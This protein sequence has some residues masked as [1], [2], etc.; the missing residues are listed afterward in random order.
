M[1]DEV[2]KIQMVQ[3][4][5]QDLEPHIFSE[6]PLEAA[7]AQF[8]FVAQYKTYFVRVL[9]RSLFYRLPE[10]R[11]GMQQQRAT[12]MIES[13]REALPLL[14]DSSERKDYASREEHI[15]WGA[16]Q[17][18]VDEFLEARFGLQATSE[19]TTT[20]SSSRAQTRGQKTRALGTSIVE[21][22]V[23]IGTA[24]GV[25][26]DPLEKLSDRAHVVIGAERNK[27]LCV[28]YEKR[29]PNARLLCGAVHPSTI[30][31]TVAQALR[32]EMNKAGLLASSTRDQEPNKE[33]QSSEDLIDVTILK[34]DIDSFDCVLAE[35]MLVL[36]FRPRF[37]V[38]E[39]NAA[40]PP[41][42]EF[43]MPDDPELWASLKVT[44][45]L[46]PSLVEIEDSI[47]PT[48][49]YDHL[50]PPVRSIANV[51]LFSCSL[52]SMVRM[53]SRYSYDLVFFR[54]GDAVFEL[55]TPTPMST[56]NEANRNIED[57]SSRTGS[58]PR[59][60]TPSTSLSLPSKILNPFWIYWTYPLG[61]FG[62]SAA[63]MRYVFYEEP[64]V[65]VAGRWLQKKLWAWG[66]YAITGETTQISCHLS[67]DLHVKNS[68][69][70]K[71]LIRVLVNGTRI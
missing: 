5:I 43:V 33:K 25:S 38:M 49:H 64:N 61:A 71:S 50:L 63:E 29:F 59:A 9:H 2:F 48:A 60:T 15:R 31:H 26:H 14:S 57:H 69:R 55:R 40:I 34:I 12:T 65:K 66:E 51:P 44:E 67:D 16:E 41:P 70:M 56:L 20:K 42:F 35:K 11:A 36:G 27:D 24:D 6:V 52:T 54:Y 32:E 7:A 23:N 22:I 1:R 53:F 37:L 21:S 8:E 17:T 19:P 39:V 13:S 3:W 47:P 4:N 68:G 18:E 10:A 46:A 28:E 58:A 62:F 45:L 30:E